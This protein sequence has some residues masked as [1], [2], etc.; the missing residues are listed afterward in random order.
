VFGFVHS[1]LTSSLSLLNRAKTESYR[2]RA[3]VRLPNIQK[4]H[5]DIPSISIMNGP[6]GDFV[7]YGPDDQVYFWWHPVS[8]NSIT[9]NVSE[10]RRY[11]RHVNADFPPGF[12]RS[13]IDGSKKAFKMLFPNHDS[14]FFNQAKVG[15]G[16]IIGNGDT[17]INDPKSG[18]HE[19]RDPPNLVVDGYISVK[20]Q[21]LTTAP[22]NTYLLE[23]ELF[24]KNSLASEG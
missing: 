3:N 10:A 1:H 9:H 16:Y 17:D 5:A 12:E 4:L 7:R 20:T 11:E 23:K 13:I 2:L 6:Y 15:A 24:R 22:Y 8:P 14:A 21:K 18:L 19:R